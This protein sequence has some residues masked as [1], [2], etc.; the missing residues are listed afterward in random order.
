[1]VL[2]YAPWIFY[3]IFFKY[4]RMVNRFNHE[5]QRIKIKRFNI[6]KQFSELSW[7][8]GHDIDETGINNFIV[9]KIKTSIDSINEY[10]I[11]YAIS[12]KRLGISKEFS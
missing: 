10:I 9:L 11:D 7:Y 3:V 8:I 5:I 6:E 1:M 2:V 12:V 4:D